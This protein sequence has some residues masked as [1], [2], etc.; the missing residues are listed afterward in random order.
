MATAE[1]IES[2]T[3]HHADDHSGHGDHDHP[4]W[5]AHHFETPE[6]QFD[7]GKLGMWLFL[8]QEV[9]FFTGLFVAYAVY[10]ANY[11][12]VFI[13]AHH[14][15]NP[16][17]GAFNTIVLLASSLAIAWAVRAA[18][19]GENELLMWLHVFTLGCAGLFMGVKAVEY[20]YKIDEGLLWASRYNPQHL[21]ETGWHT[22]LPTI[23]W[24]TMAL[25]IVVGLAGWM[26]KGK[27]AAW[28]W[29]TFSVG[30]ILMST[31]A[32]IVIAN[33][34]Q[35]SSME[36]DHA[37]HAS[38]DGHDGHGA[39]AGHGDEHG[40]SHA[41]E[42]HAD[43]GHADEAHAEEGHA[44]GE[45][46]A[47]DHAAE[48]LPPGVLPKPEGEEQ[49]GA[50][51]EG[52]SVAADASEEVAEETPAEEAPAEGETTEAAT[53]E[54]AGAE[55]EAAPAAAKPVYGANEGNFFSIYFAMT[56]VHAIHIFAG[57]I[58]FLW[59]IYRIA[60]RNFSPEFYGPVEFVGLYWHLVDLVWIY[61]F[62][63]LY[64]IH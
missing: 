49:M 1:A 24:T 11:P 52:T 51:A 27:S 12:E 56:G 64:L 6:Q 10:R 9:L 2:A 18:Q 32:G 4:A 5:L 47:E 25:G 37:Q 33:A 39:A 54:E 63:L 43:K 60:K 29:V 21:P 48:A 35:V 22:S 30:V 19:K 34:I 13:N 55:G 42:G 3:D 20:S 28:G 59:I 58:A 41:S 17:L 23:F 45:H 15:L 62:P 50:A 7:A 46:H 36:G 44:S 16:V 26:L 31:A 57:M 8:A 14:Y 38:A 53:G 40:A 61:L